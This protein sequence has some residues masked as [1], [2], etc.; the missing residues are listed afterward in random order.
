MFGKV[1]PRHKRAVIDSKLSRKRKLSFWGAQAAGVLAIAFCD[2]EL[3]LA[4]ASL[5]ERSG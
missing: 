2:R 3:L 1:R 5:P 4:F